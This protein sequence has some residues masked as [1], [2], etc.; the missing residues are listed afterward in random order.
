MSDDE[1]ERMAEH[2]IAATDA[3]ATAMKDYA[4]IQTGNSKWRT[5]SFI[6]EAEYVVSMLAQAGYRIVP[7]V[8]ERSPK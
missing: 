8:L 4:V 6:F 1:I 2:A 3:V 7:Q 5:A